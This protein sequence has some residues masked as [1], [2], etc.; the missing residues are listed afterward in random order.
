MKATNLLL[1]VILIA[2]PVMAAE[3]RIRVLVVTGGH[4]FEKDAFTRIFKETPGIEFTLAEH[5]KAK[6]SAYERSDLFQ[7]NV[8]FLYDMPKEIT[9]V[10]KSAFLSLFD[11]GIGLVV[12]HHALASFQRWPA[13]ERI[14]GGKYPETADEK[15]PAGGYEHDVQVPVVIVAKDHPI[16]TGIKDFTIHDEIYW[17]FRVGADVTQLLTTTHAKSGKP[18]AWTRTEGNSRVV[19]LQLGHDHAAYDNPNFRLLV[20]R[21]I[22]WAARR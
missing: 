10:Q 9:D 15:G 7:H 2:F 19:Y 8:V 12:T 14:I 18:L 21:S 5:A 22:Q 11:R 16:T 6:A 4:D 3:S 1:L 17:N 20:A 13:Y